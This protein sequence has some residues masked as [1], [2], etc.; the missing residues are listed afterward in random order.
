MRFGR[1]L[2]T[3]LLAPFKKSNFKWRR[4]LSR[5]YILILLLLMTKLIVSCYYYK[6]TADYAPTDEKL[7]QFSDL[8]KNFIVHQLYEAYYISSLAI[9]DD[10]LK[11]A[12][13]DSYYQPGMDIVPS[14]A[15]TVKRYHP[16]KGDARLLNEVHIY[17]NDQAV[18]NGKTWIVPITCVERMDVYNHSTQHTVGYSILFGFAIVPAAIVTIT[19]LWLLIMALSGNSC[20]FIYTYNGE[21]FVFA[22]EIYSG[23]IYPPL[24][25]DDYLLLPDLVEEDGHYSL[26]ISNEL[27]EVQHT[28]LMELMI[29][30]HPAHVQVMIDKY[31]R[32]HQIGE[33]VPPNSAVNPEGLDL[34]PLVEKED[35]LIYVGRDPS[36]DPPLLDG[37]VL[38]FERPGNASETALLIEAKNSYWLDFVYHNFREMLGS[39]YDLWVRKQQNGDPEKMTDW[40]LSQHIPLSVYLWKGGGWVFQDYFNTVGPMAFKKD[41]L[42]VDLTG[43]DPGPVKIKLEAGSYFW[44]IGFV[45][46]CVEG[47][48][49]EPQS[50]SLVQQAL[51]ERGSDVSDL[52][53]TSDQQ[54]YIQPDIGNEATVT[55]QA[56]APGDE[57]RTVILHSR[58]YY[59]ILQD[60]QGLPKV[61]DL[62]EIRKTGNFN[63][64]SN[65]LMQAML[66]EYFL[67]GERKE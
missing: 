31:G 27:E 22:G 47:E 15:K 54:Y 24:E 7:N 39:S 53:R 32:A 4:I 48:V 9:S 33:L 42:K 52:L 28:N 40:S 57:R 49:I 56:P 51:D 18:K 65:H 44:E 10:T 19:L 16:K 29:F 67:N 50:V 25:R 8:G 59:D 34:L 66:D 6:V 37:A 23:A 62:K 63:Q 13:G 21:E 64:Y 30:D 17:V 55:F 46:L 43:A 2:A 61:K 35:D 45:A 58:G 38:T 20:P 41:I 1:I 12:L 5:I 36:K 11:M 14:T 26:K 60:P 3:F